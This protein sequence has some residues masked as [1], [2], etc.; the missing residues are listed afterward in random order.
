M[1]EL[2]LELLAKRSRRACRRARPRISSG[3][4]SDGLKAAGLAFTMRAPSPR[5]AGWRWWSTACRRRG[6]RQRGAA[7]TAGRRARAGDPG[8]PEG[9]RP[10]LARPG[11]KRDTGKG[12]FW[13]AVIE[14]EGRA[15]RRGAARHHRRRHE[16]A[17]L[18]QV[19]AL[20]QR[21][22]RWVRPL[23]SHRR[24]VR[25]QGA[26]GR[27]R[28]GRRDG[29][30]QVRRHHARPSLP[31]ARAR[32]RS[33]ASP[34]TRPSSRAAHVVLDPA[35]RKKIMRRGR[36]EALRR[37][38]GRAA[39]RRRPARRGRGPGRMAGAAARPHRWPVHGRAARSADR[40]DADA[41]AILRRPTRTDG[42]LRQPLRR[43]RQQR[44]ARRRQGDRRR[45]R[46]RAARAAVATPS[47]SGTRTA[48]SR[49]KSACR[50]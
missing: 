36:R 35:E 43:R 17:A 16:G 21:H 39:G 27:G 38:A 20:G 5:R 13:F 14:E 11:E 50:R 31:R 33:R 41:S 32:S 30:D 24:A 46:A 18:A 4:S 3:W 25:R 8:L 28:A 19:D 45:Q 15:D 49:W 22:L 47:S 1:A 6:R 48:R 12:E 40:L 2:L 34:T 29:A 7:R 37:G 9:G 42:K 44:R 23:Q 10:R 26:G